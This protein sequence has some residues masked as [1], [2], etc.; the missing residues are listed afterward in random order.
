MY[1]YFMYTCVQKVFQE[2]LVFY[3]FP[4]NEAPAPKFYKIEALE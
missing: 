4:Q 1:M 2:S 3:Y